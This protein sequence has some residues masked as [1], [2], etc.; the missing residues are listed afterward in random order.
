MP[1]FCGCRS[2]FHSGKCHLSRNDKFFFFRQETT[3][4]LKPQLTLTPS[5]TFLCVHHVLKNVDLSKLI[6]PFPLFAC[7]F[8]RPLPP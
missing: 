2:G 8:L 4:D 1:D 5:R 7:L 3:A 6:Y